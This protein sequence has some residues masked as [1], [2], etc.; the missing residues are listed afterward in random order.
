MDIK[1]DC[2]M[3]EYNAPHKS[4]L[5]IEK[6]KLYDNSSET[7]TVAIEKLYYNKK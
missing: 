4:I 7:K 3:S 6:F 5:E 1:Y 2:F